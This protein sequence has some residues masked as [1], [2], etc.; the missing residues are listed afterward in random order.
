[1]FAVKKIVMYLL[2]HT[3]QQP[4]QRKTC[5]D[6][7]NKILIEVFMSIYKDRVD[8]YMRLMLKDIL[9]NVQKEGLKQDQHFYISFN[10]NCAGVSIS[11][12]LKNQ[13]ID[14]ML[15]VLQHDFENLV[16]ND[17]GFSVLLVFNNKPEN[18]HV[19]FNSIVNFVDPS[20]NFSLTFEP[21]VDLF[22]SK[23]PKTERYDN[24]IFFPKK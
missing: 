18:I 2:L 19:S 21:K 6:T 7:S 16:V 1:M 22:D 4:K 24:I 5:E 14:E 20:E 23:P 8:F 9:S 13:Y 17:S 3:Q 15:I 12:H 10:T 11:N